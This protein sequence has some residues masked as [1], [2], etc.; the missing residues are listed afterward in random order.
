MNTMFLMLHRILDV[1]KQQFQPGELFLN[2]LFISLVCIIS[3]IIYWDTVNTKV[4]KTSRCKRQMDIYNK[5]KGVYV[6]NATDRAKNPLYSVS[7]DM[8]QLNTNVECACESG[9]YV[10]HFENIAVKDLKS[11][12]NVKVDKIC[13][14]DRY[15]NVG[16]QADNV[17]YDGDPGLLRYMTTNNSEFFD[18]LLYSP[19]Q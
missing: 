3:L 10:N 2:V 4:S 18:N 13:S 5:N 7:Y 12:R 16:M 15:Y 6:L 19:Y 8:N 9:K 1:F 14:C 17:E 11:N